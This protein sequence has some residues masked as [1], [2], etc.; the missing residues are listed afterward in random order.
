MNFKEYIIINNCDNFN[1]KELQKSQDIK[2]SLL[3][4]CG[5]S[6]YKYYKRV[7]FIALLISF[8]MGV[9][10]SIGILSYNGSE[11]V[12]VS[13]FLFFSVVMPIFLALVTI[14]SLFSKRA[15][16][17]PFKW[18][19]GLINFFSKEKIEL[20]INSDVEKYLSLKNSIL[21][22]LSFA[23]G[24]LLGVGIILLIKDIAFAW[25]STIISVE[26][27][28]AIIHAISLPW[29]FI[30]PD[31]TISDEIIQKSQFFR[32]KGIKEVDASILGAW[33]KFLLFSIIFYMI[34]LRL[35]LLGVIEFFYKNA[36]KKAY[37]AR[38]QSI[39]NKMDISITIESPKESNSLEKVEKK[40]TLKPLLKCKFSNIVAWNYQKDEINKLL[41][42]EKDKADIALVGGLNTLED[43]LE[44]IKNL[45]DK[46]VVL[47][48][49]S[50]DIPTL[51]FMDF[52]EDLSK[53][54]RSVV[55]YFETLDSKSSDDIKIW[56][57]KIESFALD[58]IKICAGE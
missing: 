34:L 55:L 32:V 40:S 12:N 45:K 57:D 21:M 27:F 20:K 56:I 9:V 10:T 43:D 7:L 35:I 19:E 24:F 23:F 3:K 52:L 1:I 6:F 22:Q 51:D 54:A 50:W 4:I 33:W 29:S 13:Y 5:D 41:K 14:F 17:A 28:K 18:I 53:Q 44:V 36:L 26:G 25:S 16:F 37:L 46:D 38:L 49:K 42:Y 30:F 8:I 2:N 15:F 58:N 31:A 47:V 11:P 48:V 39:K